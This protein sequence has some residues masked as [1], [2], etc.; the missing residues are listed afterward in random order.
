[1]K[2]LTDEEVLNLANE[3]SS[4]RGFYYEET[5]DFINDLFE[6]GCRPVELFRPES[7]KIERGVAHLITA[8]TGVKRM[9][10]ATKL[11]ETFLE[12]KRLLDM[13]Y[14]GRTLDQLTADFWRVCPETRIY[15]GE[16][17]VGLYLF[18]YAK[19]KRLLRQGYSIG[20]VLLIMGWE[21][22]AIAEGYINARLTLK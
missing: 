16:K 11:S 21:S 3:F 10:A 20:E 6:T 4:L 1:M 2:E 19:A 9:I 13:A 8:K 12:S 7:W 18:R 14:Y 17:H 15:K 22:K 5:K